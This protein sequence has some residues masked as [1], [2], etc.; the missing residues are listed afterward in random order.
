MTDRDQWRAVDDYLVGLF[1]PDDAALQSAREAGGRGDVPA[2]EVSP[3]LGAFLN[4]VARM[5]GAK[6]V[7]ELGTLA[8]YSGV[9]LARGIGADGHLVT[10]EHDPKHADIAADTFARAGLA[11]RVE[12]RTGAAMDTLDAMIAQDEAPFDL[13]FI[14]AD[15]HNYPHYLA[16]VLRLSRPGTVIV[17]DNV[18]RQGAVVNGDPDDP[19]VAGLR[20]YLEAAAGP[21]LTTTCL[22]TVGGKGWDGLAI[23][24]VEEP[25]T[26]A[27]GNV[28]R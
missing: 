22:Q 6:R 2:I 9:W 4:L 25:P 28:R 18:V 19:V 16:R 23:S 13:V 21:G 12:I 5:T 27:N 17:A 7:L 11:D 10:C 26:R 20:S 1:V 8:G 24:L 15:K 14:D 3:T